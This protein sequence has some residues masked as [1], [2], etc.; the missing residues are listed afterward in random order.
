V[1]LDA[2]IRYVGELPQPRVDAYTEMD[3]RLGWSA[4][5]ALELSLVGRN[6]LHSSHEEFGPA[7]PFREEV[8]RSVYGRVTWHF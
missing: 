2:W 7:S 6:L 4:S 8:E 5:E 3:L 1:E